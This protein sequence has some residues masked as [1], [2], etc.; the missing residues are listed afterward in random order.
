LP[1]AD[2]GRFSIAVAHLQGD[3]NSELEQILVDALNRFV[4][5]DRGSGGPSLQIAA[6]T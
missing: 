2:P 3:D 6:F 4:D 1:R 5:A